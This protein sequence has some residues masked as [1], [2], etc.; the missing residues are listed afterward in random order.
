M[1]MGIMIMMAA[2]ITITVIIRR[3][4]APNHLRNWQDLVR[5]VSKL[6][7][8]FCFFATKVQLKFMGYTSTMQIVFGGAR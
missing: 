2:T 3:R 8:G 5:D 4:Q 1:I 6:R 7:M